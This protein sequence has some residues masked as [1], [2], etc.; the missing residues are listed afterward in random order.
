[1]S[2]PLIKKKNAIVRLIDWSEVRSDALF[3][4]VAMATSIL[5][6]LAFNKPLSDC[7]KR[8]SHSTSFIFHGQINADTFSMGVAGEFC[9]QHTEQSAVVSS[10]LTTYV[11][12]GA[13]TR[14]AVSVNNPCL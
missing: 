14:M 9:I 4:L 8:A 13:I 7:W 11:P 3:T 10:L 5:L 2:E 12:N 1:M 6:T